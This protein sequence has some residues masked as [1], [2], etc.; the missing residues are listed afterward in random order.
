MAKNLLK[1]FRNSIG[2]ILFKKI[3]F[4]YLFFM[5][6]LTSFQIYREYDFARE[7]IKKDMMNAKNSFYD[8]LTNS[9]WNFSEETLTKAIQAIIAS[10]AITGISVITPMNE[11]MSLEGSVLNEDKKYK[12]FIFKKGQN[13][14]YY[15]RLIT[16]KFELKDEVNAKGEVLAKVTFYTNEVQ[17]FEILKES[18]F[19]ILFNAILSLLIFWVLFMY[20]ANKVLSRPLEKMIEAA[21]RFEQEDDIR[22]D[23]KLHVKEETELHILAQAFNKMS[24]KIV[25]DIINLKQLNMIQEKQ[26]KDLEEANKYKNDFL[27][28]MSHE[29]KT[30]LNS[31]NV[32]SSVMMKNRKNEFSEEHVKNLSIINGCGNDL[33]FL[34]NDVLDI[35][36]LEAGEIILNKET[37]DLRKTMEFLNE[38]IAPQAKAKDLEFVYSCD[39]SIRYVFSDEQRIKQIIK[40]LLSNALK[41]VDKGAIYLKVKDEGDD[42]RIFVKDEGIGIPADRLE[43]IFERFKQVDGS[44]TRKYG[45]TGLGLAICKELA[46]LL[47]GDITVSSKVNEGTTFEVVIPKNEEEIKHLNSEENPLNNSMKHSE[48]KKDLASCNVMLLHNDPIAFMS[49]VIELNRWVHLTQM[50]NLMDAIKKIK[51]HSYSLV[52][53]DADVVSKN[54]L[55]KVINSLPH[56][57]MVISSEDLLLDRELHSKIEAVYQKPV[58]TSEIIET[59]KKV[60]N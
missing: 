14:V 39:E 9:V 59:M 4:T 38:M 32:I 48:N 13:I 2:Y 57:V 25:E 35:S 34:I 45:G 55:E 33:L 3:F 18:V 31:I 8:V 52:I 16:Q 58:P 23:I 11:V 56:H 50:P 49:L 42:V 53:I 22:M 36:K 40:N 17:I 26:K 20:F 12:E 60:L 7:L 46:L 51:E 29:L 47:G 44:T 30:P 54:E 1:S 43:H 10:K 5:L 41:F 6:T 28:N 15:D 21:Q 19:L 24:A 27:A 37:L